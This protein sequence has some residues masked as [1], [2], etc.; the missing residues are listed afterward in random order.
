MLEDGKAWALLDYWRLWSLRYSGTRDE[1]LSRLL[2]VGCWSIAAT[3]GTLAYDQRRC[4][5][6]D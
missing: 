2:A 3:E 1:T 5:I 6:T 4:Q